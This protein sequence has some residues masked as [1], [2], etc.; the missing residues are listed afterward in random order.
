MAFYKNKT[1]RYRKKRTARSNK[2]RHNKSKTRRV[3]GGAHDSSEDSWMIY[4][5]D[6][7]YPIY[8]EAGEPKIEFNGNIA[9][10]YVEDGSNS[11]A[12]DDIRY[13]IIINN[14]IYNLTGRT[15]ACS[16]EPKYI[17]IACF[18]NYFNNLREKYVSLA[19]NK[20]GTKFE[21]S[22]SCPRPPPFPKP[23]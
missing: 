3:K 17:S 20:C 21:Y 2:K 10:I 15:K 19:N 5:N 9:T 8:F 6:K 11:F 22:Q 4:T 1:R 13:P 18:I 14:N 12:I 7:W 16:L 23:Q